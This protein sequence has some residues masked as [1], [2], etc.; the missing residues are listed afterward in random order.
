MTGGRSAIVQEGKDWTS[1][2]H[3]YECHR[4][5]GG[6]QTTFGSYF[7]SSTMCLGS[8]DQTLSHLTSSWIR[9]H[10]DLCFKRWSV[11]LLARCTDGEPF[12]QIH[13][14]KR[15]IFWFYFIFFVNLSLLSSHMK[16]LLSSLLY[17]FLYDI[18][19]L[20]EMCG[21]F[22]IISLY[23]DI[24]WERECLYIH[25]SIHRQVV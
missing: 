9:H 4:A 7:F 16:S 11:T 25:T 8:Y 20:A 18:Q 12:W 13:S 19:A 15:Y 14:G 17:A 22:Y 5:C 24:I 6:Q 3:V 10:R 21:L 1:H 23:F 2:L